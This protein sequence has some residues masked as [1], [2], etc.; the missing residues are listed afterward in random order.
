[1]ETISGETMSN[2]NE[3]YVQLQMVWPE[4]RLNAPP[5]PRLPEGYSLR[6]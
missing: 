1:M 2:E 5:M 4:R 6:T 3:P